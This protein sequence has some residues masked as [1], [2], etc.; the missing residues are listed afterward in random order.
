[1][2]RILVRRIVTN[3]NYIYD[4]LTSRINLA[5]LEPFPLF[6]LGAELGF[7]LYRKIVG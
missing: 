7:S 4:K 2:S 6:N 5:E 3:Q 1:M